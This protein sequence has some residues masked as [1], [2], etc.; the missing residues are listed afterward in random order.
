MLAA[1]ASVKIPVRRTHQ[2]AAIVFKLSRCTIRG[3]W[4]AISLTAR[5]DYRLPDGDPQNKTSGRA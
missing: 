2:M 1:R 5:E 3:F 4:Q